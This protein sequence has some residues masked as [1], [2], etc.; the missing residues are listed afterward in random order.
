LAKAALINWKRLT[1]RFLLFAG[2]MY[3]SVFALLLI[4]EDR[5]LFHPVRE[6]EHWLPPPASMT[7]LEDVWLEIQGVKAHA[8]WSR[9]IGWEKSKGAALFFHGNGGNVSLCGRILDSWNRERGEAIL[10]LDY[11]GYGKSEGKPTEAGCYSA[12]C[13]AYDWLT[14]R[15]GIAGDRIVLVGQ[16]LGT[17]V[18]TSMAVDY[19]HRALVL[20]SP[21]TS[22]PDMAAKQ[23][24]IFPGRRFI[25]NRFDNLERIG[26][27]R[28][29]VFIVHGK[30]DGLV[31]FEHSEKIY[32]AANSPKQLLPLDGVGHGIRLNECFFATLQ[33]FLQE[34]ERSRDHP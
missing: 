31:P 8:W 24:P 21:F 14:T 32:A 3:L 4:F 30:A 16:S 1:A 28:R 6:Q 26:S 25:H 20:L 17:A 10:A 33:T 7:Q 27:C 12:A 5:L 11:P 18:A 2:A 19:P 23:F 15:Q 9:P 34:S 29:P 13:A 22:M